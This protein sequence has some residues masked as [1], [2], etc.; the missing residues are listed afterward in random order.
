MTY[1]PLGPADAAAAY[2][3]DQQC[4]PPAIAY[5]AAEIESYLSLP[6]FHLGCQENKDGA[7]LGMILT[8]PHR[9]R[10]H[11]ITVDVAV[12]ARRRGIGEHLMR[13]AEDHYRARKLRGMRL[14]AAVNNSGALAFYA[15]LGYRITVR[16]QGYYGDLDGVRLELDF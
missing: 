16:L 5:S 10:G 11:V 6:G 7:L 4:F 9:N 2:A 3:L 1:R 8:A 15:R 13:A 14:E 12:V